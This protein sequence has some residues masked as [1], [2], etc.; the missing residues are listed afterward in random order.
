MLK[1]KSVEDAGF[2]GERETILPRQKSSIG[3]PQ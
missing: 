1:I 3:G 2:G